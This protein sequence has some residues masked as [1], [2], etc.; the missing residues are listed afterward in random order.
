VLARNLRWTWHRGT[1]DLFRSIDR[2]A[3]DRVE[4]NPL[5]LLDAVGAERL[6]EL[7]DDPA[8]RGR[9]EAA[10]ADLDRYLSEPR[11]YQGLTDAP[12]QIGYFSP[13][14]GVTEVLPQAAWA[15]WR[16]TT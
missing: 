3:W 12:A 13:E 11:W 16:G 8:F 14:F 9:L 15:C 6:G 1:R 10:R 7:A 2:A 4:C 5:R